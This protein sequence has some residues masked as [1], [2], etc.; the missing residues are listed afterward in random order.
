MFLKINDYRRTEMN[1][2]T[3][4]HCTISRNRDNS[5]KLSGTASKLIIFL[6][7]FGNSKTGIRTFSRPAI[8]ISNGTQ[9]RKLHGTTTMTAGIHA[10][11]FIQAKWSISRWLRP[12]EPST[13][14]KVFTLVDS[15]SR[16]S[17]KRKKNLNIHKSHRLI[18]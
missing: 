12:K 17:S 7:S 3:P 8:R 4:V 11:T 18:R 14:L 9:I 1:F 15:L 13:S 5:E 2:V 10:S 16:R 6:C